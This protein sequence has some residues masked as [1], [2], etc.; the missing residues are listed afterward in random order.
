MSGGPEGLC[1]WWPSRSCL[2]PPAA[3]QSYRPTSLHPPGPDRNRP[4]AC[5][6]GLSHTPTD[7]TESQSMKRGRPWQRQLGIIGTTFVGLST[8][9]PCG[10][11]FAGHL[12]VPELVHETAFATGRGLRGGSQLRPTCGPHMTQ[13]YA[14]KGVLPGPTH[15]LH[16]PAHILPCLTRVL[17]ACQTSSCA[18][19]VAVGGGARGQKG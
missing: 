7:A 6:W 18:V 10:F 15:V 5:V 14:G 2:C 9:V 4:D 3:P 17:S 1:N 11:L 12:A 13:T 8:G 16:W 19:A